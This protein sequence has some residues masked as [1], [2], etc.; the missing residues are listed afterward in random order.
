ML[1]TAATLPDLHDSTAK[2]LAGEQI[3]LTN[4]S[5]ASSYGSTESAAPPPP[6]LAL[7]WEVLA[8]FKL[9]VPIAVGRLARK[10]THNVNNAFLGQ[11]GTHY[12]AATVLAGQITFF[13]NE[14]LFGFNCPLASLTAQAIGAGNPQKA[15]TWFQLAVTVCTV[16]AIPFSFVY[17]VGT[18]PILGWLSIDLQLT[19]LASVYNQITWPAAFISAWFA[20][21]RHFTRGMQVPSV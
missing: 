9:S 18:A 12:L 16:L 21:V 4:I 5:R 2:V 7:H 13:G 17:F 14:M 11:L 10:V 1:V 15:G 8:M 3:P 20:S 6:V 19:E